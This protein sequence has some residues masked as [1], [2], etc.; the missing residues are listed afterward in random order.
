MMQN[1][2]IRTT[3]SLEFIRLVYQ[4]NLT[5]TNQI[6]ISLH[7]FL[8]AVL[9]FCYYITTMTIRQCKTLGLK[10]IYGET[11]RPLLCGSKNKNILYADFN[12]KIDTF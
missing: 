11:V 3:L 12:A 9:Q 5:L 7:L 1:T 8:F 10:T 6:G 2:S 4:C